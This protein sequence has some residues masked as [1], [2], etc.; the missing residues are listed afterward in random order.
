MSKKRILTMDDLYECCLKNKLTSFSAET[1]DKKLVVT[2][3]GYFEAEENINETEGLLGLKVKIFH[4]GLNLNK[5][6]ISKEV[7]EKYMSTI[8]NRPL[9][10]YIHQLPDGS[11]D[12]MG[13]ERN[14]VINQ[15][16]EEELEY[17]ESPIG[18]FTNDEPWLEEDDKT[19]GRHYIYSNALVYEEY[20]KA[21]EILK[22]KNGSDCSMEIEVEKFEFD[23]KSKVLNILSFYIRGVTL[24]GSKVNSMTGKVDKVKPGME[25][26]KVTLEDFML[27]NPSEEG[28]IENKQKGGK[29]DMTKFEELLE[30]YN[31]TAEDVEFDYEGM[32]DEELEAK[33][34]E[35][36]A[37]AEDDTEE[38]DDESETQEGTSGTGSETE[39]E[40]G[41]KDTEDGDEGDSDEEEDETS[42][43]DDDDDAEDTKKKKFS[44]SVNELENGDLSVSYQLSH[45]QIECKI[46]KALRKIESDIREYINFYVVAVYDNRF[47]ACMNTFDERELLSFNYELDENEE[48]VIVGEPV[49][50]HAEY[51][52]DEE[53][54]ALNEMRENYKAVVEELE[55]YKQKE[56]KEEKEDVLKKDEEFSKYLE[57]EEFQALVKDMDKYSLSE[58][59]DKADVA[60]G[61]CVK[62]IGN[63]VTEKPKTRQLFSFE[64]KTKEAYGGLFK[65]NK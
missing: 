10:A 33:F 23:N 55:T 6:S 3:N 43:D 64:N 25:G 57:E 47:I 52:N 15:D 16:G 18:H 24:L 2:T 1:S 28:C 65:K 20:T 60:Y 45:E 54:K 58:F 61:K 39:K 36:F 29:N 40:D 30:K 27:N 26:A 38:A 59:K 12:F 44:L 5:T 48:I 51:L 31:K 41:S 35:V 62:R 7:A 53:Y 56:A 49:K 13:H 17:I 32:S 14:V 9:L 8:K 4:T 21:A 37:D 63:V 11:Y 19:E 34:A 46:R 22:R 42:N 50:V